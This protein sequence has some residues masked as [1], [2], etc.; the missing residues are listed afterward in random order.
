MATA[1][2][3]QHTVFSVATVKTMTIKSGTLFGADSLVFTPTADLTL[4]NNVLTETPVP[5]QIAPNPTIRRVYNFSNQ[6]TYS[7]LAQIYYDPATELNT[8]TEANLRYYDSATGSTWLPSAGS[9][10]N[11]TAHYVQQSLSSRAF[12][13]A[14]ASSPNILP[15]SLVS[16]TGSWQGNGV[17][18]QWVVEQTNEDVNFTV[19]S[20]ADANTWQQIAAVPGVPANGLYT[21]NYT[22]FKPAGNPMY[23]RIALNEASG[24]TVYSN[25]VTVHAP[26][27][28]AAN[29]RLVA[30]NTSVHAWFDTTPPAAI[31]IINAGGQLIHTDLTSH[32]RYDI[33]NLSPGIYFFQYT[34]NNQWN[35]REFL[36]P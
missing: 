20:S 31:R 5:V 18:L 14:S 26:G 29:L 24:Q 35:V 7:G 12:I 27:A 22:D 36:I 2:R 17:P 1:G 13:A 9:T 10:V 34:I 23:Y 8:N 32:S 6:F 19:F 21:Y 3:S 25:I 30:D 15:L 33:Y 11:T 16:F 28:D 4:S